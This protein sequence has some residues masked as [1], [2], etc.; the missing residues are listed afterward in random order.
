MFWVYPL[1][2]V[3]VL[4]VQRCL[5]FLILTHNWWFLSKSRKKEPIRFSC[6]GITSL[7]QYTNP[8]AWCS[9]LKA[10]C[11]LGNKVERKEGKSGSG[12][13]VSNANGTLLSSFSYF[14]LLFRSTFF[15]EC[16][17]LWAS[18][19][20]H[21]FPPKTQTKTIQDN[22]AVKSPFSACDRAVA[23]GGVGGRFAP[24][25]EMKIEKL[26]F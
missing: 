18:S 23:M 21:F 22:R 12:K 4:R 24:P 10:W 3:G 5:V 15:L 26:A 2:T 7:G 11:I 13:N 1:C 17:K 6:G 25:D 9:K 19:T 20:K 16:I 8:D 14:F